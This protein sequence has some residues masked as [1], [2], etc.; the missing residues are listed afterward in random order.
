M[1]TKTATVLLA[2]GSATLF[3]AALPRFG[4]EYAAVLFSRMAPGQQLVALA[5]G[6]VRLPYSIRAERAVLRACDTSIASPLGQFQPEDV[7]SALLAAC[8]ALA[9]EALTRSPTSSWAH[10]VA[11]ATASSD[12]EFGRAFVL[13]QKTGAF[14]GELAQR[15]FALGING[16]ARGDAA[17]KGSLAADIAVLAQFS[18][19]QV[20]L[21]QSYR[22]FPELREFIAASV[23]RAP[24]PAQNA[25]VAALRA[26]GG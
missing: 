20:L 6:G 10:L 11:A 3:A 15:R 7:R 19:G 12:A 9:Q 8:A 14:E 16:V 21:A 22:A 4:V 18:P 25:F 5:E 1:N 2:L 23:E 17:F 13:S 26:A 24:D